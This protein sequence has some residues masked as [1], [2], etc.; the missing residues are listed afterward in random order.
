[1]RAID[2]YHPIAV[3]LNCQNYY[4]DEYTRG[5]DFI[6]EDTYPIGINSTFS[7]WGT[8]CNTT[9]GDCGCDNCDDTGVLNVPQRLD[10]LNQ[11]EAWLGQW[12]KTKAHNP[13]SF[14]G[15][16]YWHRDPT[17]KEEVAMNALG[18]N[19]GAKAIVSW[20]WPTSDTLADIHGQFAN[21]VAVSPVKDFIVSEEVQTVDNTGVDVGYWVSGTDLLLCVVNGVAEAKTGVNIE[22]AGDMKVKGVKTNVWGDASWNLSSGVLSLDKVGEMETY[23]AIFEIVEPDH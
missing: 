22:L 7:K 13:Q 19:H 6:M 8:P 21:E 16:G 23:M 14:S 17:T 1:V 5:A 4:F 3:T 2:P 10:D 9:Y 11:Y 15:E 20:V 18:F 12:G